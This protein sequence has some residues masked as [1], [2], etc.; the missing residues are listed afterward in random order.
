MNLKPDEQCLSAWF[1]RLVYS[2]ILRRPW[3]LPEGFEEWTAGERNRCLGKRGEELA[4]YFLRTRGFRVLRTNFRGE[5]GGEI[6]IVAARPERGLIVF[7]EVKTR[8]S[9]MAGRPSRAVDREKRQFIRRGA[10]AW[11]RDLKQRVNYRFDIIEVIL[12]AGAVPEIRHV[13][14]AFGDGPD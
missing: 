5:N 11:L 9:A 10:R 6:D 2:R 13:P 14:E 3:R 1:W 12:G 7:C 8:S 4:V